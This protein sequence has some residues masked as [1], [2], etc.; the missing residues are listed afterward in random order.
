MP[1]T[2][3]TLSLIP[4]EVLSSNARLHWAR[5]ARATAHLR[6][7]AAMAYR[8]AG[9]P[10]MTAA[11]CVVTIAYP[12]KRARGV[13]NLMAT[14]KPIVDGF[15]HP[16]PGVRGLLPDD[17]DGHL[18]GPDLRHGGIITTGRYTLT[19]DFEEIA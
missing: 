16:F 2:T 18:T 11:R 7:R 5:K 10:Q 19:F 15:T 17:D 14:A 1:T 9:S 3:L 8:L 12:V 13:H 4:G 6:T